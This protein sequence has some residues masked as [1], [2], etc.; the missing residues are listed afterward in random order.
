MDFNEFSKEIRR[1]VSAF[2]G[3]DVTA[4]LKE[5]EKNNGVV[6]RGLVITQADN[7]L[8]PT[9]YL[10]AFYRDYLNGKPYGRVV[11]EIAEIYEK[12][13]VSAQI[14]FDFF[15]DYSAV[16]GRIFYKIIHYEKNKRMLQNVPHRRFLDLAQVC[17]YAYMNDYLGHGSIQ[18]SVNHLDYWGISE[19][20]LFL[21]AE[22]NTISKLGVETKSMFELLQEATSLRFQEMETGKS[23]LYVMTLRGRYFG[24]ACMAVTEWLKA[25]SEQ[26]GKSFYILPSSVHELILLPDSGGENIETLK[27]MVREVN[28]EHVA[29]EEVLSDNV[30]YFNRNDS[31]ILLI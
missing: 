10:E 11:K 30:Y 18:I 29:P 23:P 14:N 1:S 20:E 31:E 4:E 9:I 8:S 26:C 12:N 28:K 27:K 6:L 22:Q 24:A 2:L 3:K 25:F 21:D 13:K 19:E 7:V 5:V 17:Y 15:L 16:R